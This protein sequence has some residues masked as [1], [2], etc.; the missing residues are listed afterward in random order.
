MVRASIAGAVLTN[1]LLALGVAF[2]VGGLRYHTQEYNAAASRMYTSMMFIAVASLIVPSAFGRIAPTAEIL[3]QEQRVNV[4][5]AVILLSAYV[6]YLVFMIKTHPDYFKSMAS[7]EVHHEGKRWSVPRALASLL[8][9]SA[10]AAWMS[11][12]LVGAAEETGKALGMSEIFIGIIFLAIVGG[13]AESGAAVTAAYKNRMDLAVSIA[14][15]SCTQMALFVA[16]LLVLV[17]AVTA[18]RPLTLAF[19]RAEIWALMISVL[20]GGVVANDGRSN[21]YKGVQLLSMYAIL[22]MVFYILPAS[23]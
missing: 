21:W 14:M 17:S 15:G 6:L 7:G 1:L 18:P 8:V 2:V 9:A 10:L 23:R 19:G 11:E 22:V 12:I 20:I 4:F 16:P 13:A 3:Q 5:L